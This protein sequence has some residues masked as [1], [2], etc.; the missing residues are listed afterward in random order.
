MSLFVPRSVKFV[1]WV[2]ARGFGVVFSTLTVIP[3]SGTG[4]CFTR[5][6]WTTEFDPLSVE[7]R[8][9]VAPVLKIN[10]I[11]HICGLTGTC[12][13]ETS[14]AWFQLIPIWSGRDCELGLMILLA[15]YY[16][17]ESFAHLLLI[18][19]YSSFFFSK[20][21]IPFSNCIPIFIV[22]F[23]YVWKFTPSCSIK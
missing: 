2:N 5:C 1:E 4:L 21:P 7:T 22:L 14:P 20:K 3:P 17:S 8:K 18:R 9:R 11:P 6:T 16:S 19:R 15:E 23:V 12:A 13:L 10:I